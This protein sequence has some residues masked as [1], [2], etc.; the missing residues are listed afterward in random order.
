MRRGSSESGFT[1]IELLIATALAL[2]VLGTAVIAFKDMADMNDG[3][4]LVADVNLGLRSAVNLITQDLVSAGRDIPIGGIP[5]PSGADAVPL[6]RPG[7]PG[8]DLTFA[9]DEPTL[10]AVTPGDGLGPVI[11]GAATDVITVLMADT[12]LPLNTEFLTDIAA[13]GSSATVDDAIAIDDPADGIS[14]GDLL[15]LSNPLGNALVMVTGRDGQT[16]DFASGDDMNLNQPGAG[17]GT[18]L[19]LQSAPGAYPDTTATRILMVTY[20]I[21]ADDPNRPLLIRRLNL[22][23]ERAIAVGVENVQITYDLVDGDSN[24]VNQP[25][26][27]LPNTP[28]E[29]RKANVFLSGRSYRPWWRTKALLRA[30]LSTQ[31]SLRSLSF[32][33]RY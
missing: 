19:Q 20:Y 13:D 24:P 8:G 26:P 27:V 6:V 9:A 25:E 29:I 5:I 28:D 33:D 21:N 30:S 11:N 12:V 1:I 32:R 15:M 2:A 3:V 31:V 22:G 4:A 17:Q 16:I 23:P 10:A 18:L 7:P 14:P